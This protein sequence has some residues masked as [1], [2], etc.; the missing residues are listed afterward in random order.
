MILYFT[1]TGNSKYIADALANELA[2][3]VIS[4]NQYIKAETKG[5]FESEKPY[6]FVAPVYLA[7]LPEIV[8]KFISEST[9]TG[10]KMAYFISTCASEPS[11]VPNAARDLCEENSKFTYMGSTYVKMPQNY[12]ALFTMTPK[13]EQE[14]RYIAADKLVKE[15]SAKISAQEVIQDNPSSKFGYTAIKEVEKLYNHGFAKTK[16]F[17]AT[18][19]CIGCS[20]CEKKCP[21][22]AISMLAKKPIWVKNK[23]IHCMAC[24]NN[25]P[26]H[27]IEYGKGTIN[28]ERYVCK[29]Y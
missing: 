13:E 17:K 18:D 5:N 3:E 1:G 26:K 24:I 25:C 7:T 12:I 2:D 8:R 15:I 11:A 21:V 9:F 4:M 16:K 22:N 28:K 10:N 20:V 14:S 6:V 23:C 29:P 19:K 27:A